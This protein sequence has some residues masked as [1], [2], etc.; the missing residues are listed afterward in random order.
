MSMEPENLVMIGDPRREEEFARRHHH[1]MNALRGNFTR[2]SDDALRGAHPKDLEGRILYWMARPILEDDFIAI[3]I[4]CANGYSR[5]AMP[6]LRGM[7]ERTV[8][9]SYL[10]KHPDEIHLYWQFF[11]VDRFKEMNRLRPHYPELFS[12]QRGDEIARAYDEVKDNYLVDLCKKCGT[13]R[14]NHTWSKKD[15]IAM[16]KEVG[17]IAQIIEVAYYHALGE[18]H[19][20]VSAMLR[21]SKADSD[22][23]LSY[24]ETPDLQESDS[25]LVVAHWMVL[26]ALAVIKE[27]FAIGRLEES[28]ALCIEDFVK[29]WKTTTD[30]E[31]RPTVGWDLR[32]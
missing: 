14:V 20:K 4:L 2:A 7:F 31:A 10:H 30:E 27:R 25:I 24:K 6:V 9:M 15:M 16:A 17:F 8:T 1:F 32:L 26:H 5:S 11:L 29:V 19:S 21:R 23:S 28:L 3:V 13:K 12:Q 18:S 22:D